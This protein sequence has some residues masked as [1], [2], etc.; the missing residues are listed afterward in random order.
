MSDTEESGRI[1]L[2][3]PDKAQEI[4]RGLKWLAQS[5]AEAG[6]QRDAQRAGNDS[7]WWLA[8][9]TSL[10]QTPPVSKP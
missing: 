6:M 4:A 8:Y 9:S 7:Q 1:S 2:M 5:Y 3:A 10:A